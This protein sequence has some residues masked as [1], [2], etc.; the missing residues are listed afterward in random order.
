MSVTYENELKTF[1]R[2]YTFTCAC[3]THGQHYYYCYIANTVYSPIHSLYS[4]KYCIH[5][6]HTF[7]YTGRRYRGTPVSNIMWWWLTNTVGKWRISLQ[8]QNNN[9]LC[10]LY[11]KTYTFQPYPLANI[12]YMYILYYIT[13]RHTY[14]NIILYS[15]SYGRHINPDFP[16]CTYTRTLANTIHLR[17]NAF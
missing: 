4:Y 17:V 9:I 10:V 1:K 5:Y 3:T 16:S 15:C 14:N 8:R 7:C 11:L 12:I 6:T 2:W 13:E